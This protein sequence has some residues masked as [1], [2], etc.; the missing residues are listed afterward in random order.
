VQ[1]K[2]ILLYIRRWLTVPY[3]T[4]DGKETERTCGV[5]QG[6]VV[7][8]LLANLYLH[9]SFDKWME[10]HYPHILF[11]R[12]ADDVVCHCRSELEALKLREALE[13]RLTACKLQMHPVKTKIVYCK[14]DR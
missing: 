11:E 9:Y 4:P 14:D 3:K 7:G 2:W 5:P 12:Y 8:P 6:S 10:Q 1:E 13:S